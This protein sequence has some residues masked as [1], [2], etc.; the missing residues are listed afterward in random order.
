LFG[1]LVVSTHVPLQFVGALDG[2]A[3]THE[4]SPLTAAHRGVPPLHALPQPPQLDKVVPSTQT[5]LHA[6]MLLA[7]TSP[8]SPPPVAGPASPPS[9]APP[10]VVESAPGPPSEEATPASLPR[11][12]GE[13]YPFNPE[14]TAHAPSVPTSAAPPPNPK[15]R[16]TAQSD[17]NRPRKLRNAHDPAHS[18]DPRAQRW[19]FALSG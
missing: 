4:Y 10:S 7:Q 15:N 6:S 1:S 18:S 12:S 17:A 11:L 19:R 3:D 2:H 13:T 5:P 14:I 9:L 8:P 16:R